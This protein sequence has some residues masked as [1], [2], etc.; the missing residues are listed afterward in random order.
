MAY[1]HLPESH[2]KVDWSNWS[3]PGDGDGTVPSLIMN[4]ESSYTERFSTVRSPC[5]AIN[6]LANHNILPH[7]GKAITQAMAVEALTTAFHLDSHIAN[8]FSF[9]AVGAN[10]DR[11]AHSFDLD[12][13]AKHGYI[14]HDVSLSRGDTAFGSN[15][16]FDKDL[17]DEVIRGLYARSGDMTNWNSAD[18]V[19]YERVRASRARHAKEGKGWLFGLKE[20]IASYGETAL[21]LSLLGKDGVAPTKW[22]QVFFGRFD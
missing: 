8:T 4:T 18:E 21:Y 17:F 9:A 10:P 6:A 15:S 5:P 16:K 19:R 2:P 1:P 20:A 7:N 11:D 13:L 12:H 3:P 22:V 14:E